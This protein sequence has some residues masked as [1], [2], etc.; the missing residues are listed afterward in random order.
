MSFIDKAN[1]K[2]GCFFDYSK[3]KYKNPQT[4]I[5]I[6]CPIHGEFEQYPYTH[7]KGKGCP[8]CH[9]D[10]LKKTTR[11]FKVDAKK[12]HGDKYDYSKTEYEGAFAKVKIICPKHGEFEQRANDH[13]NQGKGC[14]L[15]S[16]ETSKK[17]LNNFIE[18]ARKIHGDKYDY[19]LISDYINNMD[20]VKIICPV[21]GEFMQRPYCHLIK[22]QG[23]PSCPTVISKPHQEIIDYINGIYD[24]KIIINDRKT[25]PSTEL[26]LYL[27]G[28]NL[29]I[30]YHGLFWHSHDKQETTEE[31]KRHSKKA[32][33]CC[34]YGI[35]LFQIWEHN[36]A[37][38]QKI[39]KS[40]ISNKLGL[41]H[42]IYARKCEIVSLSNDDYLSFMEENHLQGGVGNRIKYGLEYKSNLVMAMGFNKHRKYEWEVGRIASKTNTTIVG[43]AS[44]LFKHFLKNNNANSILSYASRD[45]SNGVV[46]SKLG[47]KLLGKTS[48]GYSYY[49]NGIIYS[50]QQFQKHK[51]KN[52]LEQF[53]PALSESQNMFNN[54]YRRFWNSGN[55]RFLYE[56]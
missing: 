18:E 7:L 27:P 14:P 13:V 52:K 3:T 55:L 48:P 28:R 19:S 35:N 12:I 26:D 36:W 31:R 45:H 8:K 56:S 54:G 37:L 38:N 50:R 15:C 40:M 49:K 2:H 4:K 46:Y 11:Q 34:D 17:G 5:K 53:D 47:F 25:I 1:K 33:I 24:G 39:I 23:C 29:A 10:S 22:K 32:D 30:E 44:K 21:H 16:V 20:K 43:G 42:K 6:I 51:L 9:L 41:N